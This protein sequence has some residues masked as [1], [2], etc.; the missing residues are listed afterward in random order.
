MTLQ[1]WIKSRKLKAPATRLRNGRAVRLW[2]EE[3]IA[4]LREVKDRIYLKGVG[5]PPK[6]S[7]K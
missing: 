3:D 4:R 5:R 6:N 2:T 7:T 1:S